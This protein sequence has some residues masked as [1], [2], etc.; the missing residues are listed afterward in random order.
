[1]SKWKITDSMIDEDDT[2]NQTNKSSF[3]TQS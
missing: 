3:Q 2:V 1:M